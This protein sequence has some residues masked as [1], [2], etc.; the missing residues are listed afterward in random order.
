MKYLEGIIMLKL[1]ILLF[2]FVV[3]LLLVGI[4]NYSS[5]TG[6]VDS[7]ITDNE[8]TKKQKKSSHGAFVG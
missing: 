5:S 7:S 3:S 1:K 4:I 2:I 8:T 6:T